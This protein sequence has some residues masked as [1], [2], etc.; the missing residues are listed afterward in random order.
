MT[1]IER[2]QD[3]AAVERILRALPEWFAIETAIQ[4]YV[5]DAAVMA[6]YVAVR[7][8]ATAG[9]ALVTRHFA[10]SA[11]LFL[12]AVDPDCRGAG[13]GRALVEAIEADLRDDAVTIL[14][15][16]TVGESFADAGYA[17]TR[18]FYRACGFVPLEEFSALVWDGPTLVLVKALS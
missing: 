13:I 18:A 3:P 8:G 4:D 16:K 10:A 11:E 2:R 1:T 15:V 14:Q 6:S 9:V 7:R 5:R 12:I 17:Q